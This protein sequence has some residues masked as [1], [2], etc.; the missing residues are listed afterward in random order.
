MILPVELA[1]F[2]VSHPSPLLSALTLLPSV[3]WIQCFS[4]S[5]SGSQFGSGIL[6]F[7]SFNVSCKIVTA[8]VKLSDIIQ[9]HES[10]LEQEIDLRALRPLNKH[11]A[12]PSFLLFCQF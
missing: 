10:L 7:C 1:Y 6:W 3:V 9:S 2:L 4:V 11:T 5:F 12:T 8:L